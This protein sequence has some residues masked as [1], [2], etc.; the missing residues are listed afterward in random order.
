MN[1]RDLRYVKTEELIIQAFL[2][3]AR[4]YD[5]D[6]IFIKDICT[7]ARI[8]RNAFYGH[9]DSKEQVLERVCEMVR[10]KILA[11]LTPEIIFSIATGNNIEDGSAWVIRTIRQNK[12]MLKVIAKCSDRHFRE[13]VHSVFIESTLMFIFENTEWIKDDV[14]LRMG[15]AYITDAV[16]SITRF[17]LDEEA[18]LD[19]DEVTHFLYELSHHSVEFFYRKLDESKKI[20]RRR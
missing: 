16:T 6:D 10:E 4:E 12:D 9:Y 19:D 1:K 11:E 18:E 3:C 5:F 8:S 17:I 20:I 7:K 2:S 15:E 14:Y 13:L